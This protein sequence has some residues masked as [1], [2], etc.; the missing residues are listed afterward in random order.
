MEVL[1]TKT[2]GVSLSV[3]LLILYTEIKTVRQS[4]RQLEL[5]LIELIDVV[6]RVYERGKNA[7]GQQN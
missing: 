2:I 1:D 4:Q 7:G 6:E 3:V 5:R